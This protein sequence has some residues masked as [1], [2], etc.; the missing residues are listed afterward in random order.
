MVAFEL[1]RGSVLSC[2]QQSSFP[3]LAA[4]NFL[5]LRVFYQN[6]ADINLYIVLTPTTNH[7]FLVF[8]FSPI[9]VRLEYFHSFFHAA[10]GRAQ[11]FNLF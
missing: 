6:K 10:S 3:H 2:S 5:L 9:S 11:K 8:F 4:C 1:L 7:H